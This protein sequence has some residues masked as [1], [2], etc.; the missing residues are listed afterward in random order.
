M[1]G[2][3]ILDYAKEFPVAMKQLAQWVSEGKV[4]SKNTVIEGGLEKAEHALVD[5]FRG[6]NTGRHFHIEMMKKHELT[7]D[8]EN[9]WLRSRSRASPEASGGSWT[10]MLRLTSDGV[11]KHEHVVH[12]P[13]TSTDTC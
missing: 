4:K 5:L 13:D 12:L 8:Q 11:N 10:G 6:V 3:I 2:F 1:E 9:S 7:S